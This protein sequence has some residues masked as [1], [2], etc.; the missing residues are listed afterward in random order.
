MFKNIT[1]QQRGVSHSLKQN[2]L[3]NISASFKQAISILGASQKIVNPKQDVEV[4]EHMR[5]YSKTDS[6]FFQHEEIQGI[7]SRIKKLKFSQSKEFIEKNFPNSRHNQN[8]PEKDSNGHDFSPEQII[9]RSGNHHFQ[10][11]FYEY[12]PERVIPVRQSKL[13]S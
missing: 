9:R 11:K 4:R 8:K 7:D 1:T 13:K 10:N 2:R 5:Q 3:K 12:S 6:E